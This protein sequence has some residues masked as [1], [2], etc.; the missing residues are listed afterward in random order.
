MGLGGLLRVL[1][2]IRSRNSYRSV[3]VMKLALNGVLVS[4][5]VLGS[6]W[7]RAAASG[8]VKVARA[9]EAINYNAAA[10]HYVPMRRVE[11]SFLADP[12]FPAASLRRSINPE[13]ALPQVLPKA[14]IRSVKDV[15]FVVD[16]EL[17]GQTFPLHVDTGCSDTWLIAESFLCLNKYYWPVAVSRIGP[18]WGPKTADGQTPNRARSADSPQVSTARWS[19][20]G[21]RTGTFSSCTAIGP[22]CRVTTA[23]TTSP[24]AG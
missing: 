13:G 23:S 1:S 21:S 7:I 3:P 5:T 9:A 19:R 20:G 12:E 11:S 15:Y 17:G 24:S 8:P 6:S 22:S 2:C 18:R 14:K 16:V 4:L 10:S